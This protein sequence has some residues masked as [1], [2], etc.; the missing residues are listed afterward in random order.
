MTRIEGPKVWSAVIPPFDLYGMSG[1]YIQV[2][3][4]FELTTQRRALEHDQE[5]ANVTHKPVPDP[6]VTSFFLNPLRVETRPPT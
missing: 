4:M 1:R 3:C 2:N 5:T 6:I